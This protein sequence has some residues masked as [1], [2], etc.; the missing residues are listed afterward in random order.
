MATS[1]NAGRLGAVHLELFVTAR[2]DRERVRRSCR[3]AYAAV[4]PR[5]ARAGGAGP[6]LYLVT[7]PQRRRR[8]PE[9]VRRSLRVRAGEDLWLELAFYPNVAEGRSIIRALWARAEVRD[10]ILAAE[11]YNLRRRGAWTLANARR[12]PV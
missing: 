3:A 2:R 11:R 6:W 7:P 8:A 1:V 4:R 10:K 5:T 9:H 12:Q